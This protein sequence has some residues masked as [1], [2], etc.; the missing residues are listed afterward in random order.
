MKFEWA[1]KYFKAHPRAEWV[2]YGVLVLMAVMLFIFSRESPSEE[3]Q[4]ASAPQ[5]AQAQTL[6]S[7]LEGVLSAIDGAGRVKVLITYEQEEEIV[8]VYAVDEQVTDTSETRKETPATVGSGSSEEAM[9]L[10]VRAAKVRGAVIVAEGAGDIS[11][12]SNLL[13]AAQAV[14]D[15][16]ASKIEV[17]SM[18]TQ[19]GG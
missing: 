12:R 3:Q 15:V 19:K 8:P 1:M 13:K 14:L 4:P 11:V 7:Q 10:T 5:A 2:F 18:E 17:F 6:E 16:P 9:V